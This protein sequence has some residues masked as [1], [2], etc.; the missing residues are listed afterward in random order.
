[1]AELA[2]DCDSP[3]VG[4]TL[5]GTAD[6]VRTD[7]NRCLNHRNRSEHEALTR[8]LRT[9]LGDAV[10]YLAWKEGS[11]MPLD[12]AVAFAQTRLLRQQAISSPLGAIG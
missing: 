10:F 4:A 7:L 2:A 3:I 11:D 5:I 6:R 9:L 12:E 1:M 8:R